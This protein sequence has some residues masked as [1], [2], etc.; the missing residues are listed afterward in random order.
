[1]CFVAMPITTRDREFGF[2]DDP[3]HWGN[4]LDALIRPGL[5][6]AGF[7][8]VA[9]GRQGSEHITAE[10]FRRLCTA[11]L[12]LADVSFGNANVF[13]EFG[14]RT[15]LNLPIAVIR[16]KRSENPAFDVQAMNMLTYEYKAHMLPAEIRRLSSHVSKAVTSCAG[17][18]PLWEQYGRPHRPV[19]L[20]V[21]PRG[22]VGASTAEP[23]H[24]SG[25]PVPSLDDWPEM[26]DLLRQAREVLANTD[27]REEETSD[28]GRAG[29]SEPSR[30]PTPTERPEELSTQIAG[31]LRTVVAAHGG[32]PDE[33][34][35]RSEIAVKARGAADELVR[36][37]S[38]ALSVF[39]LGGVLVKKTYRLTLTP[40]GCSVTS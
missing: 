8:V 32:K 7:A 33:R 5:E 1:M 13:F 21:L 6:G 23:T 40:D 29:R 12:V 10:I 30:S 36:D 14:I 26:R 39:W 11:D 15:A 9:P 2:Y 16:D 25:G 27:P 38:A 35:A 18:N 3:D 4:L 34:R 22:D 31:W 20:G 24:Q 28:P 37:G 17:R 19:T